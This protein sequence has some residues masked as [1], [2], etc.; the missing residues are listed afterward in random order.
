[1]RRARPQALL[2]ALAVV[3]LLGAPT[4]ASAAV[5]G[6]G[7]LQ[8]AV[9]VQSRIAVPATTAARTVTVAVVDSGADLAHPALA[10]A[11]WTNPGETAGNGVDD[12][13]NGH[14]DDVHGVNLLDD[15]QPP[16]D[17][18]GHGT[19]VAGIVAGRP[20]W[21]GRSGLASGVARVMVVKVLGERS[22]GSTGTVAAGIR[23][24]LAEGAQIINLSVTT[25]DDDPEVAAAVGEAAARGV[26]LVVAAGN[27]GRDLRDA[28]LY[29]AAYRTPDMVTV[30][31]TDRDGYLVDL[32]AFGPGVDLAAPGLDVPALAPGGRAT[33]FS[34]TSAAAPLVSGAAALLLARHPGTPVVTLRAALLNGARRTTALR[35]EIR[36]GALDV[37][38]AIRRLDRRAAVRGR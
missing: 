25:P 28:P 21:R 31:A 17:Q 5:P 33:R 37:G 29:P 26:L 7:W 15:T 22:K 27:H 13:G 19:A 2:L 9:G 24:A 11:L 1:M 3:A 6:L 16:L 34:G 12:D 4:A 8:R 36:T 14:V 20:R 32:S 30:G 23:Y 35:D 18:S 38:R 10:G